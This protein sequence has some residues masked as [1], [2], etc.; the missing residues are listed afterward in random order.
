M[1]GLCRRRGPG[2]DG[3]SPEASWRNRLC[4]PTD[5]NIGRISIVADPQT[6]TLALV[7]GLKFGRR[8]RRNRATR[9]ASAGRNC[10]PPTGRRHLP[11][12]ASCSA[13][14]RRETE[15]DPRD[16]YQLFSAGGQTT[17]GI[18]T[19]SPTEQVPFWLY[20]FNVGDLDDSN[21]ACEGRGRTGHRGPMELPNGSWIARCRD[22]QG[23]AFALQGSAVR[24]VS[25]GPAEWGGFT[26]KGRIGHTA[27]ASPRLDQACRSAT[28]TRASGGFGAGTA[29]S[30]AACP[31]VST[32][33]C[34]RRRPS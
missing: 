7:K 1:G 11:F 12:T 13:G 8:S 22:P 15:A 29:A 4:P 33:R 23:A 9:D 3:R 27:V 26:S 6:A 31:A 24:A 19:K 34:N 16:G 2:C 25:A 10:L 17:G 32:T 30:A 28:V 21:G 14:R 5:T 20:Y 18:F